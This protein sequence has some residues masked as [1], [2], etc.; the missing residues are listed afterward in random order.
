MYQ[1]VHNITCITLQ[2]TLRG[3]DGDEG[4]PVG[5]SGRKQ[6]R[7]ASVGGA[8]VGVASVGVAS[9]PQGA[10]RRRSRRHSLQSGRGHSSA[11]ASPC[12]SASF[13]SFGG[14]VPDVSER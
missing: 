12:S 13:L 3:E 11:P 1:P 2:T 10:E 7:R 4:G 9:D 5:G 14:R 8:S 6:R